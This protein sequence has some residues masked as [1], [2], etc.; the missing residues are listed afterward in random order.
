MPPCDHTTKVPQFIG[1]FPFHNLVNEPECFVI[2]TGPDGFQSQL[3]TGAQIAGTMSF[4]VDGSRFEDRFPGVTGEFRTSICQ[5]AP[6]DESRRTH[7]VIGK[8]LAQTLIRQ[9]QP[10]LTDEIGY[11]H[12]PCAPRQRALCWI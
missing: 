3:A 6:R 4:D 5:L 8:P 10:V 9:R 7:R 2:T 1:R 11:A 12:R